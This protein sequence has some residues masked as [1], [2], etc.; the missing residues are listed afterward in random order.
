M[1]FPSID[2][3]LQ[4]LWHLNKLFA[5]SYGAILGCAHSPYWILE[6]GSWCVRVRLIASAQ[7]ALGLILG[8]VS[9]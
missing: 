5:T 8:A 2:A 4:N 7:S 6:V 1:M 3:S 9:C